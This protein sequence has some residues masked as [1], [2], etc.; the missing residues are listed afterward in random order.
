M[1]LGLHIHTGTNK[2]YCHAC[3][4]YLTITLQ[5]YNLSQAGAGT[6]LVLSHK[7]DNIIILKHK[8]GLRAV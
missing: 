2:A 7:K 6:L 4:H 8:K 1:S 5:A 3:C